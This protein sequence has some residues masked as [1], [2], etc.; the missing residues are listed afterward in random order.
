MRGPYPIGRPDSSARP[1]YTLAQR[2][3]KQVRE[4]SEA[5]KTIE[6]SPRAKRSEA[7]KTIE[8]SP[9]SEASKTIEA[10]PRAKR[11]ALPDE[12]GRQ[13][14]RLE[15]RRPRVPARGDVEVLLRHLHAVR[16][17]DRSMLAC[18]ERH[19]QRRVAT[20]LP[21]DPQRGASG[22]RLHREPTRSG[23]R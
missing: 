10:S 21:I 2:P 8:A 14:R 6:A 18:R 3:S 13:L 4:Q 11:A 1:A 17:E 19:R 20:Q 15:R 16:D 7:S 9:R 12:P 22:L 23:D 5:S